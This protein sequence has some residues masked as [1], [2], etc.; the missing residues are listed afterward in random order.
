MFIHIRK[1]NILSA[2]KKRTTE[3]MADFDSDDSNDSNFGIHGGHSFDDLHADTLRITSVLLD[4]LFTGVSSKQRFYREDGQ[5]HLRFLF[6]HEF[7]L[8][9]NFM[10]I[11][12]LRSL[13]ASDTSKAT[14]IKKK[15]KER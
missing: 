8:Y 15:D 9:L 11:H 13:L 6:V 7:F 14:E 1:H 2:S 10:V 12:H 4:D 5:D 3:T